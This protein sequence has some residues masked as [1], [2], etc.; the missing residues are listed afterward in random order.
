MPVRQEDLLDVHR[1]MTR[2]PDSVDQQVECFG[3]QTR[4]DQNEAG[5]G[6][7]QECSHIILT[8]HIPDMGCVAISGNCVLPVGGQ[9]L[10]AHAQ[11]TSSRCVKE[12]LFHK[13]CTSLKTRISYQP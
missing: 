8:A 1:V 10:F 5:T 6:I 9:S 13:S 2:A 3:T 4:I 12:F 11:T 7:E